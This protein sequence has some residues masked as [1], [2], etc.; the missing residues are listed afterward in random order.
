MSWSWGSRNSKSKTVEIP[1]G[2]SDGTRIRIPGA[3]DAPMVTKDPYNQLVNGDL[4]IRINVQK[5]PVFS[6]NKNDLVINEE[7][8]MTTAALGGEIVVPTLDGQKI[9]LKVRPGVQNGRKLTI[10]E[11]VYQ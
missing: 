9:K 3:G 6:R 4:I 7:I 8:L 11:K 2:V 10:P 5:D 1:V